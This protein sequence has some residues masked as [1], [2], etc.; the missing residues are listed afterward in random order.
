MP[1]TR[2]KPN[3][4]ATVTLLG[5]P[6]LAG[7]RAHFRAADEQR[8]HHGVRGHGTVDLRAARASIRSLEEGDSGRRSARASTPA[9]RWSS[10]AESCSMIDQFVA[11]CLH[12]RVAVIVLAVLLGLLRRLCLGDALGGGLS[13]ARRRRRAGHHAGAGTGGRGSRAADHRAAGAADQRH[14][15]PAA[16]ALLQ[17]L[18]PVAHHRAVPRRLRGLLGAAA[19]AR[20]HQPGG[21]AARRR[22]RH[23][24]RWPARAGR[25]TAT[26]WSR[27]ARTCRSCR[28]SS[29]GWSSRR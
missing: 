14:A 7:H 3:M 6:R 26:R 16:H 15:G 28:R 5:P 19:P 4:F 12:R 21:A 13:G 20:A 23:S 1:T 10:R 18:R 24:I 25:S 2:L 8:P 29:A 9:S 17:H 22:A 27:T 11:F